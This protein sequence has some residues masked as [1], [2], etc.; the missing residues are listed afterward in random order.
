MIRQAIHEDKM[1]DKSTEDR[2]KGLENQLATLADE[3]RYLRDCEAIRHAMY[4]YARGIDRGDQDLLAPSFHDDAQDDHGNFKGD[5]ASALAAF[6][7]ALVVLY[8]AWRKSQ[9]NEG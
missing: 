8:L 1:Q 2:L 4:A 7:W 5:K 9:D 3:V 6:A